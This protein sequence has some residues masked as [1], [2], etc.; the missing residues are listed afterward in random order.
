M[1]QTWTGL[2]FSIQS[3]HKVSL[4]ISKHGMESF[5]SFRQHLR[6]FPS[7]F[8]HSTTQ[9]IQTTNSGPATGPPLLLFSTWRAFLP[10]PPIFFFFLHFHGV[11]KRQNCPLHPPLPCC[12]PPS[13]H[14]C[15][16]MCNSLEV[17]YGFHKFKKI[18]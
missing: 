17:F 2:L 16:Q 14:H 3:F 18:I 4:S 15:H 6:L 7:L 1:K 13:F 10:A 12:W 5:P 8:T 11:S 9:I